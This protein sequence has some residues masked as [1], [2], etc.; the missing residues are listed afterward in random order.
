MFNLI[1]NIIFPKHNLLEFKEQLNRLSENEAV[2]SFLQEDKKFSLLIIIDK[3]L[4]LIIKDNGRIKSEAKSIEQ[5][6]TFSKDMIVSI[7]LSKTNGQIIKSEHVIEYISNILNNIKNQYS[8]SLQE[9]HSIWNV[10]VSF[11]QVFYNENKISLPKEIS[12]SDL[13]KWID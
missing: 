6:N 4:L 5:S 9:Q 7:K 11:N 2:I 3:N 10:I 8:I 12:K 13:H 1:K